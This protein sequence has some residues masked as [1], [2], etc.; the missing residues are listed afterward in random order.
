MSNTVDAHFLAGQDL[1]QKHMS[2]FL[3]NGL[4]VAATGDNLIPPR[5]RCMIDNEKIGRCSTKPWTL[6]LLV[7]VGGKRLNQQRINRGS[8]EDQQ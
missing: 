7:L 2:A 8:T 3:S 1:C 5:M 6:R 4:I